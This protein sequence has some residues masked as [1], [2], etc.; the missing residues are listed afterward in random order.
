MHV[1]L[2][3]IYSY[4][5]DSEYTRTPRSFDHDGDVTK[6]SSS[7]IVAY[8]FHTNILAVNHA[9]RSEAEELM[10]K[11]N[12]F[13]I[14]SYQWPASKG[15]V[16][17][18]GLA[19]VP[20]VSKNLVS[21]MHRHSARI[22]ISQSP[23]TLAALA[24][25]TGTTVPVK[26]YIILARDIET[27]CTSVHYSVANALGPVLQLYRAPPPQ[28]NLLVDEQ[29]VTAKPS[30]FKCELRDTDYRL[31]DSSTQH[32]LLAPFASIV[33]P[34]QRVTFTG[35]ICD[36]S[37]ITY[38]KQIMGPSTSCHVARWASL[39]E[40]FSRAKQIADAT[41]EIDDLN[42]VLKLYKWIADAIVCLLIKPEL[43]EWVLFYCPQT[44]IDMCTMCLK[45]TLNIAC[46]RVKLGN[47]DACDKSLGYFAE[48][49][50]LLQ[51]ICQE[52]GGSMEEVMVDINAYYF[53]LQIWVLLHGARKPGQ[54][55]TMRTVKE[56]AERLE[57]LAT[58]S[59][60]PQQKCMKHDCEVLR[61]FHNQNAILCKESWPLDQCSA[62]Q[63]PLPFIS[64]LELTGSLTQ[65]G[66]FE[67][68]RDVDLLH[69]L[70][71]EEKANVNR[72]QRKRGLPITDFHQITL[73]FERLQR[74]KTGT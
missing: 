2:S 14:V 17:T 41:L 52:L 48:I 8:K 16:F 39:I 3:R 40:N 1:Y 60:E 42:F 7:G 57:A 56:T 53:N 23:G 46:G 70:D 74:E 21:R 30:Q 65:R 62:T 38:L 72:L 26:A 9:I 22:H 6:Q 51:G 12:I 59:S 55:S 54:P 58:V 36:Q 15:I 24:R 10:Y 44:A 18:G 11:R 29:D 27:F 19:W 47:F 37:Q 4:L 71:Q 20:M 13:V 69:S 45:V 32:Q 64:S 25:D 50:L 68:W 73:S 63:M 43:R 67:G 5:L 31:M 66:S 34:S 28:M 35:S 61:R 49:G 33:G